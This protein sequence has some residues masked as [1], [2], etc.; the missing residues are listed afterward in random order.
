MFAAHQSNTS[1][2]AQSAA[3]SSEHLQRSPG[4][5]RKDTVHNV[6]STGYFCWQLAT[7]D[8]R[9]LVNASG[10]TLPYG[11]SE[12][13]KCGGIRKTWSQ[14][15]PI[16]IPMVADSPVRFECSYH[17]TIRLPANPP[18]GTVDIVIGRV[19]GIHIDDKVL[20]SEG[21]IDIGLTQP[22]ARLGYS[23]YTVVKD[24]FQMIIPNAH[25][26]G[27]NG[28]EGRPSRE[29]KAQVKT[30]AVADDTKEG[31]SSV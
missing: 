3:Q 22:I 2:K 23:D 30:E 31:A 29:G 20:S 16:K 10:E 28:M 18:M 27:L 7:W 21:K 12:F 17:S 14:S 5:N 25:Q 8:L 1:E 13:D 6:E 15:L 26:R 19:V 24:T 11:Q 9:E 4:F